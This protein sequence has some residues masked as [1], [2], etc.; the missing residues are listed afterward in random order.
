MK[1]PVEFQDYLSGIYN[2]QHLSVGK[3]E[4]ALW[5]QGFSDEEIEHVKVKSIP[6]IQR[7]YASK[8]KLFP[9]EHSLPIGNE[10]AMLW[11][12]IQRAIQVDLPKKNHNLF[13]VNAKLK[14]SIVKSEQE[15]V[16]TVLR[17]DGQAMKKHLMNISA[18]RMRQLKWTIIG[19]ETLILGTPMLPL[20]GQTYWI[21]QDFMLP[22]G[23]ELSPP[24]LS[25]IINNKIN[26][27]KE[28]FVLWDTEGSYSLIPKIN[29]KELSR[30]SFRGSI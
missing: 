29:F 27:T 24:L 26:T 19:N 18:I 5:I 10:P 6:G 1:V 8:G 7:F 15:Q 30:S 4:D 13:E 14:V 20:P 28:N 11:T 17:V 3:V 21:S 22:T 25:K 9:L 16:A 12:P 23:Y 2:W